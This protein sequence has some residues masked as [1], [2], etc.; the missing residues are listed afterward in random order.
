MACSVYVRE[1][2]V[3]FWASVCKISQHIEVLRKEKKICLVSLACGKYLFASSASWLWQKQFQPYP[4]LAKAFLTFRE[5]HNNRSFS[6]GLGNVR[7]SQT[8]KRT[9]SFGGDV[10]KVEKNVKEAEKGK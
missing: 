7:S 3:S 1:L 6:V 2:E 8:I 9:C 5:M 4:Q 10:E